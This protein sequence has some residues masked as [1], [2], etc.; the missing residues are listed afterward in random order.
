[1][2]SKRVSACWAGL[3][4]W[5]AMMAIGLASGVLIETRVGHLQSANAG[6]FV[7]AF[8]MAMTVPFGLAIAAIYTPVALM[9]ERIGS[10][11][12][13]RV[14]ATCAATAPV[15]GVLLIVIGIALWGPPR[16]PNLWLVFTSP[17]LALA[18][19]GFLFGMSFAQ[20]TTHD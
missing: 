6:E 1:M 5:F 10:T 9:A 14:G 13:A 17:G 8:L 16:A 3:L 19:G 11:S 20:L 2:P 18:V 4:S 15:A 7:I 12:P